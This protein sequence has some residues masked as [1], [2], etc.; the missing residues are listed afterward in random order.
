MFENRIPWNIIFILR[1]KSII[2]NIIYSENLKLTEILSRSQIY[3][4]SS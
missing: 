3:L 2:I 1:R 4:N